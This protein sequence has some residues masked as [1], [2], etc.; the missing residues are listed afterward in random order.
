LGATEGATMPYILLVK[1]L[2]N[3]IFMPVLVRTAFRTPS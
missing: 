3:L 2:T 1:T